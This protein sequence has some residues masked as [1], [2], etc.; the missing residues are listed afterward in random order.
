MYIYRKNIQEKQ[1]KNSCIRVPDDCAFTVQ[2]K[3]LIQISLKEQRKVP[4]LAV[5]FLLLLLECSGLLTSAVT[6]WRIPVSPAVL[7]A[8]TLASCAAAAA[9]FGWSR[10]EGKR[11]YAAF[12]FAL[13]ETAV[14]FVVRDSFLAGAQQFGNCLI[15]AVNIRYQSSIPLFSVSAGTDEVTL[16]LALLTIPAVFLLGIFTVW[17]PDALVLSLFEFPYLVIL[18]LFAG[19][20]SVWSL[21][22]LLFASVGI[23]AASGL[24]RRKWLWGEKESGQY[25]ENERCFQAVR[26]KTALCSCIAAVILAIPSFYLV[27][28]FLSVQFDRAEHA[29]SGAETTLMEGLLSLL[30]RTGAGSIV[31]TAETEGRGVQD[32]ALGDT[33]GYAVGNLEDLKVTVSEEP[34]ETIYLKGFI[35]NVYGNN[36][37]QAPSETAFKSASSGWYTEDDP[38]LYIQ[39]LPFLRTMYACETTESEPA[40]P[41]SMSVERLNAS[42]AY[43]YVPYNAYLNEYYEITGGDGAAEGQSVQEDIFSCYPEES[44]REILKS[45]NSSEAAEGIMDQTEASYD[46]YTAQW[47]LEIPDGLDELQAVCDASGYVWKDEEEWKREQGLLTEELEEIEEFVVSW[48]DENYSYDIDA[49]A[50]PDGEDFLRYFLEES[51]TG[52]STHFATA[53]V[54]MFRMCG[55]P[56]RYVSGYAAPAAL[57]AEQ[58]DGSYTAVL[59]ADNSH[60]WAEIY[61]PGI[62]WR[63]VETTPGAL[64]IK[65]EKEIQAEQAD[66]DIGQKETAESEVSPAEK[67]KSMLVFFSED[68]VSSAILFIELAVI[69][70]LTAAVAARRCRRRREYLGKVRK[71]GIHENILLIFSGFY[72]LLLY[73]GMDRSIHSENPK[74]ISAAANCCPGISEKEIL[75]FYQLS[76]Q[77]AYSDLPCREEDR[78]KA[79]KLYQK[80]ARSAKKQMTFIKRLRAVIWEGF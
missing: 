29:A 54:I 15:D 42:S 62:G 47:N 58:P 26:K 48:L 1:N 43:T 23:L 68:S 41:V 64:G 7:A 10:M 18:F 46:A 79:R 63:P 21:F 75:A 49:P 70:A 66:S 22:F 38:S 35:G 51:K 28:P 3:E 16:F 67:L 19:T 73:A 12:I 30:P 59:Q 78:K 5:S 13:T 77:A 27:R 36:R 74:F 31:L 61:E 32:G 20:P 50:V 72:S 33:D 55:V 40:E 45:W 9:F 17:N 60:A 25:R 8:V 52:Y 11:R 34:Q 14:L 24:Y 4:A 76:L 56:A 2:K 69:A 65:E 80:A 6:G 39:N 44:C 37:W 57:F 53:A 71:K